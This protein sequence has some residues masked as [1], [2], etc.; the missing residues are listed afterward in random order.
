MGMDWLRKELQP[1]YWASQC[2]P[3]SQLSLRGTENSLTKKALILGI[4]GQ[5]GSYLAELLLEKGYQV[6]GWI[7]DSIS[8]SLTNIQSILK[9]I[10][11]IKGSLVDAQS[12]IKILDV[13]QPHEVYNLASPSFPA[14]SWD[15]A[16]QVGDIAGLGVVRLLDAIRAVNPSI[17]FYQAST[18]EL[19]G[20]PVESPQNENTPF[21]PRNPYGI[22]KL[23]AHWSVVRYREKYGLFAVSGILYNHESPRRRVEFVTRKITHGVA[24]IVAGKQDK[25]LLGNIDAR[26]DWGYAP[27]Y[28]DAMWRMLQQAE[29]DDYVIGTGELHSIQDFLEQ[30]FSCVNLDWQNY[31][32]IDKDLFRIEE[33]QCL[34]AN[35]SNALRNLGWAPVLSFN[36]LVRIMVNSDLREIV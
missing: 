9:Q 17:R 24:A 32:E 4:D 26:R 7:P 28:V 15:M 13:H 6:T 18:S 31:V 27:E 10:T 34:V 8:V 3:G 19:F 14:G 1:L 20:D 23:Y 33:G 36:N 25:I 11:L 29:P 35:R 30:A 12:L 22:A 16:A 21:R 2:L 5:D